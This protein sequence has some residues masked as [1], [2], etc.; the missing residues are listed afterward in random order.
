MSEW[1]SAQKLAGLPGLPGTVQG[2]NSR[3]TR[4]SWQQR[5]H[6]GRPARCIRRITPSVH[7]WTPPGLPVFVLI[8][9][10]CTTA[11]VYPASWSGVATPEP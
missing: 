6:M 11:S 10:L 4:D 1:F 7:I 8:S 5:K 3:A 9:N 2:I